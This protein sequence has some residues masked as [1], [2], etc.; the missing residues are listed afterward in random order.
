MEA[1]ASREV[2]DLASNFA[3]RG[4]HRSK[5]G[6]EIARVQD[7]QDASAV[8]RA[9]ERDAAAFTAIGRD[10]SQVPRTVRRKAPTKG[11]PVELLRHR[12]I[13]R[14][15]LDVVESVVDVDGLWVC[16]N[17]IVRALHV[18]VNLNVANDTR[19]R[20]DGDMATD[21]R[22]MRIMVKPGS[23][24]GP[25]VETGEGGQFT[26]YVRERAVDGA[27]NDAVVTVLARHLE[28]RPRQVRIITGHT[29]RVKTVEISE[30]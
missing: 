17:P 8:H 27:A 14:W 7:H 22:R 12:K 23:R 25:L 28:L 11:G 1:S 18:G 2:K 5:R 15:N 3:T 6:F 13:C 10:D 30:D 16:H 19:L 29:A 26:V 9:H 4:L 21:K 20:H 24:K